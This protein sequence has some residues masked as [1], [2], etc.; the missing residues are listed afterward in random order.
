M[1]HGLEQHV[2]DNPSLTIAIAMAVGV[3]SVGIARHIRLPGIVLLL[4]AGV[5]LGPDVFNVIRP[6][7]LGGALHSLVGF[8][9]AVILFEG[10]LNLNLKRLRKQAT[11]IRRLVTIGAVVTAVG[12]T[13]AAR[14]AMGWD[15]RLSIL[16]GTLVIVTGPTVITPL[17]RRLKVKHE[18]ETILEAEGIF[19]DAIGA[20]IAVVAL[21]VAVAPSGESLLHGVLG[22]GTRIGLGALIGAAGGGFLAV[23]LRWRK[24]VPDGLENV[25]GLAIALATF[26]LS[27]AL[28]EESGI[29]AAIVAGLIAG[30]AGSHVHEEM[31][32]FKE[33][34][35][36]LFVAT[37]FVLLSADVRLADVFALGIPGIATVALLILV[38]RP[39]TVQISMG[40]TKVSRETRIFT[41]WIGPR[42]IV[43]AAVASLFAETLHRAGIE[44]GTELRALVFLVIALTVTV[45]G[46]GGGF[47]ARYLGIRRPTDVGHL[48]LG[49][50]AV[51]LRMGEALRSTGEEVVFLDANPEAS[52]RAEE[53]GF[54]VVYGNGLDTRVLARAAA[55]T[56]VSCTAVTPNESVNLLFARR[57][58]DRFPGPKVYVALESESHGVT[59]DMVHQLDARVLFGGAQ[60]V[61]RWQKH[62]G[63]E[64]THETWR[65]GP[66]KS[67]KA[68]HPDPLAAPDG[69]LLPLGLLRGKKS[70][71]PDGETRIKKGDVMIFT[72]APGKTD[73][74]RDWLTHAGWLAQTSDPSPADEPGSDPE[75]T[76]A[77][78][79]PSA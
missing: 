47:V 50:N 20:T 75:G 21:E 52:R 59:P 38:V 8:L 55:D 33:Q 40:G 13:V 69:L 35:T 74:A 18:A 43:A 53:A 22:I 72:Y 45:A 37:L 48:I 42:G 24:I 32:E 41:A 54:K 78:D 44:G 3:L 73:E 9:V 36:V 12:G 27:N 64:T 71:P 49:A 19:I 7:V 51:G 4:A 1:E 30:N 39:L 61:D 2:L 60:P 14:L 28:T 56:R 68:A 63:P 25:L 15:W 77:P 34:L 10:G 70:L 79:G 17:L 6:G 57:I 5:G 62:L 65:Y 76:G 46:L 66:E 29:T 23:L 67:Q 31:L 26:Q 58:R 16:F 11:P